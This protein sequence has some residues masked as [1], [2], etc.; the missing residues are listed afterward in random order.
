MALSDTTIRQAKAVVKACTLGDSD[1]LAL[2]VSPEGKKSW[3][4]RYSWNSKQ[5]SGYLP[6]N[7]PQR[8]PHSSRHRL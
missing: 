8:S 3:H 1:G 2:A 6:W 4:F 7:P 5:K